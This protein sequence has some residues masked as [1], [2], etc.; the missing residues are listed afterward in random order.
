LKALILTGH[1]DMLNADSPGWW[2]QER[3]LTKPCSLTA[4]QSVVTE[5]IGP[6]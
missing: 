2:R 3:H 4:L 1:G 5:L 6:P